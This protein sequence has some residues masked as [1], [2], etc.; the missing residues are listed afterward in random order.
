MNELKKRVAA[1]EKRLQTSETILRVVLPDETTK[2]VRP[3]DWW[4]HRDEWQLV[5]VVAVDPRGWPPCVLEMAQ[6]FDNAI[7]AA[8]ANGGAIV[9]STGERLAVEYLTVERDDLITKFF[10]EAVS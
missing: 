10:G 1:L 3:V 4:K 8:K 5:D 7:K 2:D 6:M 9:T